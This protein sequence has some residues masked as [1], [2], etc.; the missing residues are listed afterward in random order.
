MPMSA[1]IADV[2]IPGLSAS[3]LTRLKTGRSDDGHGSRLHSLRRA[4]RFTDVRQ[5]R[6]VGLDRE[7]C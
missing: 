7:S 1:F 3:D 4:L 5:L 6:D 2:T